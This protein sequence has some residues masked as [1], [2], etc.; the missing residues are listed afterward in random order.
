M[1]TIS[2][3]ALARLPRSVVGYAAFSIFD[4]LGDGGGGG[5]ALHL[6]QADVD[7]PLRRLRVLQSLLSSYLLERHEH[8]S[9]VVRLTL[10]VRADNTGAILAY[11][12]L[13]FERRRGAYAESQRQGAVHVYVLEDKGLTNLRDKGLTN[14]RDEGP[15]ERLPSTLCMATFQDAHA[16]MSAAAERNELRQPPMT[17]AEASL[18]QASPLLARAGPPPRPSSP[19]PPRPP[20][21]ALPSP[22]SPPRPPFPALPSSPS[23]PRP[24]LPALPSPPSPPRPTLHL[25]IHYRST[26]YASVTYTLPMNQIFQTSTVASGLVSCWRRG[27]AKAV[28]TTMPTTPAMSSRVQTIAWHGCHVWQSTASVPDAEWCRSS[29]RGRAATRQ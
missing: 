13:G 20:L 9:K 27:Q 3:A 14:L 1:S 23:P 21:L 17:R 26:T 10:C 28:T 29:R 5:D 25:S 11:T 18:Q 8:G 6:D 15:S 12:N 7:V 16:E 4:A 24:P 19:S 22:P 2:T